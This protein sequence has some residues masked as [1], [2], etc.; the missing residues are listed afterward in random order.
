MRRLFFALLLAATPLFA[1]TPDD[2]TLKIDSK[3]LGESRT[4]L[5]HFPASYRAG[6][7]SYPV[8]YMTDAEAQLAHTAAT[9]TFLARAG[10]MPEMIVVG[11][12]NL[13]RTRDLTPTHVDGISIDG[14]PISFPTSGG[15]PKFLTFFE[16]EL[17]PTI[18]K[19]YR[20][21]P[22]RVFAGHSFGGLFALN[23][24]FTRPKLFNAIIA[25]SP[26]FTWDNHWVLRTAQQF[27]DANRELNA[28]LVFTLAN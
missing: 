3:V 14:Q 22:Y 13:D 26:S 4:V 5:V 17:I 11:V 12:T 27:V 15:A 6:T 25:V 9:A 1:Q 20:T 7:R 19:T 21:Q 10:R 8:L 23:A 16:T 24:L 28:M 18:E 2:L